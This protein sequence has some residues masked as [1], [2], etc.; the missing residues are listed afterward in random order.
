MAFELMQLPYA[1]NALEP[2]ISQETIEYHY[3]KHH[4]GYVNNTNKLLE[5]HPLQGT[6]LEEVIKQ[7]D[8][9]LFNNAAQVF[10]HDF[11]W[12]CMRPAGAPMPNEVKGLLEKNFGS[13]ESFKEQF[14]SKAA[15]LFGSG[16]CWLEMN[17]DGS[18]EI[19]Q[20]SN[21]D[22]PI[23][24]NKTP[25]LVVDVWEHA[26]YIDYRNARANYLEG[27]YGLI[28]WEFVAKQLS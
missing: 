17:G 15:T 9:V 28:D 7:S 8:G 4:Q 6:S 22:T 5:G 14:L 1:N 21:A 20:R 12:Q 10:N 24:H 18:V 13:V 25:L 2:L 3:G 11:Y 23:V 27:W 16:W 26:Y 19:T